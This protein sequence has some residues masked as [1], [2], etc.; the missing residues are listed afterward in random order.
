MASCLD[1][2]RK[3]SG[4]VSGWMNTVGNLGGTT[5]TYATGFIADTFA[6]NLG[7]KI[8]FMA[9]TLV[10]VVLVTF[11]TRLELA[12]A[13]LKALRLRAIERAA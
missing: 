11:R 6:N 3:Y 1:I 5:A 13:D 9:F 4:I 10:Y 2:G 12:R 7:W 8:N